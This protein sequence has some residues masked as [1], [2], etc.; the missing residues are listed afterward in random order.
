[1][2][3]ARGGYQPY[4]QGIERV[5]SLLPYLAYLRFPSAPTIPLLEGLQPIQEKRTTGLKTRGYS[6]FMLRVF[7]D[8]LANN[9]SERRGINQ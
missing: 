1:M 9:S 4:G 6:H 3:H 2:G 7:A 8:A 5:A